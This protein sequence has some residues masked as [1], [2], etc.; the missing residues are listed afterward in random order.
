MISQVLLKIH[1]IRRSKKITEA[2]MAERMGISKVSYSNFETGK[3]KTDQ[4]KV[5]Q[6]AALLGLTLKELYSE[7]NKVYN[8][9]ESLLETLARKDNEIAELRGSLSSAKSIIESQKQTIDALKE[10]KVIYEK[11]LGL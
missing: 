11:Q 3:T 2:W 1:D 6:A 4:K 10:L 7:D 5:E 8:P 9:G